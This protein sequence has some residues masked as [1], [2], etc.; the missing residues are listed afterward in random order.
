MDNSGAMFFVV[1]H[2]NPLFCK[3]AEGREDGG[4]F[5]GSNFTVIGCDDFNLSARWGEVADLRL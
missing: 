4:T 1:S 3:C 5:P 2:S